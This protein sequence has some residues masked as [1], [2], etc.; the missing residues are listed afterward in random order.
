MPAYD[1]DWEVYRKHKA[2]GGTFKNFKGKTYQPINKKAILEH[3][4]GKKTIGIYPLLDD[5][6]SYFIA[7]D[8]DQKNWKEESYTFLSA[9]DKYKFKAYL[10]RSRSGNGAHIWIFFEDKYPA[11]LSRK[12]STIR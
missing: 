5:N 6:T 1:V 4:S 11:L 3:L 2:Q 7:A 8:F 12:V 9:C 10:E